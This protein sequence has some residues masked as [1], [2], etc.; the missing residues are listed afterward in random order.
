MPDSI[1]DTGPI[2][3][4]YEIGRLPVLGLIAPLTLP[5][6]VFA[7]LR[8]RSIDRRI[9]DAAGVP[10]DVV[11]V[12][13]ETEEPTG[14]TPRLQPADAQVLALAR[15]RGFEA[16][17]VTDDLALRRVLEGHGATVV[18]SVGLLVRARR[19]GLL[20]RQGLENAIED[21]FDHSS[22]HLSRAFRAYV[23]QLLSELL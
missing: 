9:L 2:L 16:L 1:A 20:S 19:A 8:A 23:E 7:E 5:D 22:L 12:E 6:L 3:H 18:G 15:A 21:L 11:P 13:A 4:L 17:L 14:I 10:F